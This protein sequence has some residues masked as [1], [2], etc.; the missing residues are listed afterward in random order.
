M[1]TWSATAT[2]EVMIKNKKTLTV[3]DKNV[4]DLMFKVVV[5]FMS[6]Q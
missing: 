2:V 4:A 5:L 1:E 3:V 6:R